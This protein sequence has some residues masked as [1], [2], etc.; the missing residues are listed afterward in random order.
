MSS[1]SRPPPIQGASYVDSLLRFLGKNRERLSTPNPLLAPSRAKGSSF[2][3]QTWTVATLGLDPTSAPLNP[4]LTSILS[5]GL[6]TPTPSPTASGPRPLTLRLPPDRLL[7]LL[8]LFQAT[9]SLRN[10]PNIGKIDVPLPDGLQIQTGS[11]AAAEGKEGDVKSVSSWVGSVLSTT[12][13]RRG[14][15]WS[16]W[17]KSKKQDLDEDSKLR[18]IYAALSILPSLAI[19]RPNDPQIQELVHGESYTA[20]GGIEVKVPLDVFRSLWELEL[21]GY[22]P[23]GVLLPS[24]PSLKSLTV[25]NVQ[26]GEDWIEELLQNDLPGLRHLR[27]TSCNLLSLPSF[28]LPI[29]HLDLSSNLLNAIP[30]SLASLT[31]LQSLNLSNNMIESVRGAETLLPAI[32]AINLRRN[33][34]DCLAGLD[35][36]ASLER[37]D[38]RSN[39]LAESQEIG[40]LAQLPKLK[41]VW[42]S[43]NEFVDIEEGWRHRVFVWFAEEGNT[44]LS[45]DGHPASWTEK[46]AIQA[47]LDRRG[48]RARQREAP[49][50]APKVTTTRA[51]APLANPP[52]IASPDPSKRRRQRVVDLD[53]GHPQ[54]ASLRLDHRPVEES[55]EAPRQSAPPRAE[56]PR[57]SLTDTIAE[58]ASDDIR[59]DSARSTTEASNATDDGDA[60][61]VRARMEALKAEAGDNWLQVL[62]SQQQQQQGRHTIPTKESSAESKG[63]EGVAEPVAVNVRK[64]TKKKVAAVGIIT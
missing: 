26:D 60:N 1:P 15:G 47:D 14:S 48:W 37:C 13:T 30:P 62:A 2:L 33:R 55:Q 23:R 3:Q 39:E 49:E 16:G 35:R 12:S 64:K 25:S 27:L 52:R 51:S 24:L 53:A 63:S 9:P 41:E 57:V 8:L 22:D 50:H 58:A 46:R 32:R 54:F 17:L 28:T 61:D 44:Q 10:S 4:T 43:D 59:R 34:I 42:A 56:R 31:S 29:V 7:F 11:G 5:L 18:L 21:D 36:V 38:V 6:A 40:R 20:F 19:H 45:L